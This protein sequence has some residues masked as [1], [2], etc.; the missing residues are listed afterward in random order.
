MFFPKQFGFQVNNSTHHA[1][2]NLT[3]DILTSFEKGQFTLGVF[4]D[5]SK[6]FDTVNHNILLHKLEFYGIRGKCLSWFKS[7]L[8]DRQQFV[9][10]GSYENSICRIITCGVPQG[11]ILGPLLFLIYIND[12]FRSSSKLTPIMFADDTN[13]FISDSNIENLFETMNEEL[14]KVANWF[15][16]NKL[17]LNISKT[18]YSLFRSTRKR[19]DIPNI[20]PPLHIDNVPVKR[21]FVTKFLGVYLDE[22]IS[23]KHYINIAS[24]KVYKS[25][26][27]L[28][29]TRCILSKFLRKQLYF[30]FINCYLNYANIAWVSTNKS[31]LQALYRHQ[32]HAARIINFK[33]KFTSAKPLLEQINAMTAYEMNIS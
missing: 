33:D 14:R 31:K 27:I 8:K 2:L 6:A 15:K 16:A 30:S 23:W 1:I 18:K 10:L 9:S 22:N 24:T 19:K 32:K 29:R 25:I 5:L 17:S 12:L 4:I 11:S 28:Y 21:E 26:G 13:L 3:D 7:Y 20:L